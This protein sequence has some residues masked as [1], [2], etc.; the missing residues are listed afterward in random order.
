M[1]NQT[2]TIDWITLI[3]IFSSFIV[4]SLSLWVGIR[5]SRKTIFIN[6][7]TTA[8]IKYINDLRGNVSEF[9]GLF[10][11][12]K[13]LV[14]LKSDLSNEKLKVLES[15]DRLKY[16]ITLQLNPEDDYWDNKIIRLIE[17]IICDIDKYPLNK[18]NELIVITQYLLKLEWEGAKRESQKGI[19]KGYQKRKLKIK[20][21]N[22][23]ENHIRDGN[24]ESILEK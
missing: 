10:Y 22:L 9:C 17:E 1:D 19:L 5:N 21:I 11:R 3:G 14:D 13:K 6:S 16:L 2:Q 4:G 8:R 24:V 15:S 18:I 12:Y 7:I 23:Y 20:Y